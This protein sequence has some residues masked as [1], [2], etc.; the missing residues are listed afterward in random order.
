MSKEIENKYKKVQSAISNN[1]IIAKGAFI[2]VGGVGAM[3]IG[4]ISALA[5]SLSHPSIALNFFLISIGSLISMLSC[6]V[7]GLISMDHYEALETK[8]L[9]YIEGKAT[10]IKSFL[11]LVLPVLG[12]LYGMDMALG[13]YQLNSK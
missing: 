3:M 9:E 13:S 4:S 12:L 8:G 2:I 6:S 11:W 7:I 1:K 5:S 10:T